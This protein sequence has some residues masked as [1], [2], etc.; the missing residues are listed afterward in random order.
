MWAVNASGS[1]HH[2]PP[3][4]TNPLLSALPSPSC[5]FG[6]RIHSLLQA[7]AQFWRLGQGVSTMHV[8]VCPLLFLSCSIAGHAAPMSSL[9]TNW[10]DEQVGEK[11][12]GKTWL[13]DDRSMTPSAIRDTAEP[14]EVLVKRTSGSSS[15]R[16]WSPHLQDTGL[17]SVPP[18]HTPLNA[19]SAPQQPGS[20]KAS[21]P[22]LS[23]PAPSHIP[24]GEP[25]ATHLEPNEQY[26]TMK[27]RPYGSLK[28][29]PVAK[30]QSRQDAQ[31]RSKEKL[32]AGYRIN[33]TKPGGSKYAVT[34]IEEFRA[35]KN[36]HGRKYYH[37]RT[38]DDRAK[39]NQRQNERRRRERELKKA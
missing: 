4:L 11:A 20:P 26:V 38:E 36:A 9:A 1:A 22:P 39:T 29:D 18:I 5:L 15:Q 28:N 24:L 35:Y 30:A 3:S 25:S 12:A 6:V 16:R 14:E 21:W 31:A 7:L 10:Q 13:Y 37:M 19:P 2:S 32:M 33:R 17:L 34:T 27:R 23:R 8:V